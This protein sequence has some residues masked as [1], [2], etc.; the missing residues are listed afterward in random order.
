[1]LQEEGALLKQELRFLSAIKK[2][3]KDSG[4][5]DRL[6]RMA[7]RVQMQFFLKFFD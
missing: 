7:F 2:R 1:M 5:P 6:R 3:D 4:S